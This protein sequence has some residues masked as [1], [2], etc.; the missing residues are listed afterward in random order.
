MPESKNAKTQLHPSERMLKAALSGLLATSAFGCSDKNDDQKADSTKQ[1]L[2]DQELKAVCAAMVADAKSSAA[3]PDESKTEDKAKEPDLD[4]AVRRSAERHDRPFVPPLAQPAP[5]KG[6]GVVDDVVDSRLEG[7]RRR[8]LVRDKEDD[9]DLAGLGVVRRRAGLGRSCPHQCRADCQE[10][11]GHCRMI[12]TRG[13][14][15]LAC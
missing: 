4:M 8:N 2:S 9:V 10:P 13:A 7:L 11:G 14:C 1:E 6:L 12:L 3:K 5:E 15:R